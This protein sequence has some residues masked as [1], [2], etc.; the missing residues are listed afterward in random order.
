MYTI[1]NYRFCETTREAYELLQKS[2]GNAVLAGGAWLRMTKRPIATALDLTRIPAMTAISE[3]EEEIRIGGGVSL[4]QIE[5]S[6]LLQAFAGGVL[7][8]VLAP[9][10]GVQLRSAATIGGNV[11][12]RHGFSDPLCALLALCAEVEFEGAG[13][14]SLEA[15]L[16]GPP[17]R[18]ILAAVYLPKG[19]VKAAFLS[20]RRSATDFALLNCCV[21]RR[22]NE[23]RVA[24]GARPAR[25]ALSKKA[26]AALQNGFSAEEAGRLAAEELAFGTDLRASAPYRRL[27]ANVLVRRCADLLKEE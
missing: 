18:D 25:A 16:A 19:P 1:Q 12:T 7:P 14:M 8:A 22:N 13:R 24:I 20:Q 27:I 17:L 3:T 26:A 11:S 6:P 2:R 15:F 9:I 5:T 21:C 4:R 23:W 10:V